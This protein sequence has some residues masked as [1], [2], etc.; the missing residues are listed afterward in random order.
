MQETARMAITVKA[1]EDMIER[2][3]AVKEQCISQ[4]RCK[5]GKTVLL[6]IVTSQSELLLELNQL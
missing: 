6:Y 4:M 2:R 3:V 1:V 5:S